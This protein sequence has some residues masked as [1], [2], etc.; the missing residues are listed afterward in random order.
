MMS[1][2]IFFSNS[3]V[4]F[5]AV[6]IVEICIDLLYLKGIYC[7]NELRYNVQKSV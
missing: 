6:V 4:V 1:G 5:I 7:S 3:M 2:V